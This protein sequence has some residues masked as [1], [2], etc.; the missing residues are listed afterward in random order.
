MFN[1]VAVP[2]YFCVGGGGYGLNCGSI[3]DICVVFVFQVD[4]TEITAIVSC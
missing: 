3:D 1:V 4:C 2:I